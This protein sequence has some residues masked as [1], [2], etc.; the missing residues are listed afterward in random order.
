MKKLICLSVFVLMMATG[1]GSTTGST[2]GTPAISNGTVPAWFIGT[3]QSDSHLTRLTIT[4]DADGAHYSYSSDGRN[5]F[6]G[7]IDVDEAS[8]TIHYEETYYW[9]EPEW[10]HDIDPDCHRVLYVYSDGKL[11]TSAFSQDAWVSERTAGTSG[12]IVGTWES[13]WEWY[14]SGDNFDY[15]SRTVLT[16]NGDG[17]YNEKRYTYDELSAEESGTYTYGDINPE[18][19][20]LSE[21]SYPLKAWVM[22]GDYLVMTTHFYTQNEVAMIK[23]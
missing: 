19:L 2:E 23:Q 5:K 7:L 16:L 15:I 10:V 9:N 14:I 4:E 17:T 6:K 12:S 8:N 18:D 21:E 22:E 3:W 1:C 13:Q 20:A 11:F